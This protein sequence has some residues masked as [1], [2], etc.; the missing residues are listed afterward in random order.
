MMSIFGQRMLIP[1]ISHGL[2]NE[3][4]LSIDLA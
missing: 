3:F 1:G 2:R 4:Y